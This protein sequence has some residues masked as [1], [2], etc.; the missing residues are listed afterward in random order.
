MIVRASVLALALLANRA[1][2]ATEVWLAPLSDVTPTGIGSADY[3]RLVTDSASWADVAPDTAVFKI[4]PYFTGRSPDAELRGLIRVLRSQ[5]IALALEGRVLSRVHGCDGRRGDGGEATIHL[6]ERIKNAG[7]TVAYLA[8]DEPLKHV[9][10]GPKDCRP[11]LADAARDVAANIRSYREVFPDLR[12]GD[13]EP[14]GTWSHTETLLA[15]NLAWLKA[16]RDMAGE[17]LAFFH[18]DVGWTTDWV[19][20]CAELQRDLADQHIPFGMIYNG[21]DLAGSAA[22]WAS[23]ARAHFRAFEDGTRPPPDTAVIQSWVRFPRHAL[24]DT[25]AN[26]LTGVEL[27]YLKFRG[28]AR[29]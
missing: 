10:T 19:G 25:D 17:P 5:K 20:I 4:Y 9:T 6:M 14:I 26:S 21:E 16:Y 11:T 3:L 28:L 13:I 23:Q 18:A 7:G 15:D 2:A 8:M 24:P 29:Q 22:D 12:V 1:A 27:D